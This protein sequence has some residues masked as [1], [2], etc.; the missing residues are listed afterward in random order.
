MTQDELLE[1]SKNY[2]EYNLKNDT[3]LSLVIWCLDN[4]SNEL[5]ENGYIYESNQL[6]TCLLKIKEVLES[7]E[8]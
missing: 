3:I 5:Y 4:I 6:I 7:E 1:Q 8:V 2:I